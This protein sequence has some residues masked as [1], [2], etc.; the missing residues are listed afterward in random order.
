MQILRGLFLLAILCFLI[1]ASGD[2]YIWMRS[3]DV[4]TDQYTHHYEM[5]LDRWNNEIRPFYMTDEQERSFGSF[6]SW[7]YGGMFSAFGLLI[8][9]KVIG[10]ATKNRPD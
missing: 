6:K 2:V 7:M 4:P 3:S 5:S 10:G 1:G 9:V 8:A